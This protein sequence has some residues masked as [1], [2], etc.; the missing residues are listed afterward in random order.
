MVGAPAPVSL[1]V[2]LPASVREPLLSVSVT[3]APPKF[4]VIVELFVR[5]TVSTV[6]LP[7][8]EESVAPTGT[9]T[10]DPAE[11]AVRLTSPAVDVIELTVTVFAAAC[12]LTVIDVPSELILP[13]N[14]PTLA[15]VG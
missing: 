14:V 6:K 4:D 3:V 15:T 13:I 5:V 1:T 8:A 12:G 2:P 11:L 9:F 7:P 10:L